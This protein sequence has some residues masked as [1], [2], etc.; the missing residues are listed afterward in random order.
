MQNWKHEY[1]GRNMNFADTYYK[2][3]IIQKLFGPDELLTV[4]CAGT[5]MPLVQCSDD[6]GN[7][8]VFVLEKEE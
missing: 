6:T 4:F 7:D 8:R 1:K 2:K 3:T 5:N